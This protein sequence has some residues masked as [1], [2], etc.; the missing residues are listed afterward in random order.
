MDTLGSGRYKERRAKVRAMYTMQRTQGLITQTCYI[1]SATK[2]RATSFW[3]QSSK[4][5][6]PRYN[7]EFRDKAGRKCVIAPAPLPAKPPIQFE[8]G[9]VCSFQLFFTQRLHC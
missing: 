4:S 5:F 9:L 2:G 3:S 8:G 1:V 7:L 6:I